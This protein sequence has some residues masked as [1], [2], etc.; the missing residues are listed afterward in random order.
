MRNVLLVTTGQSNMRGN[1]RTDN[2]ASF[3]LHPSVYRGDLDTRYSMVPYLV[4]LGI[5]R[6]VRYTCLHYAIGESSVVHWTGRV[7]ATVTGSASTPLTTMTM[8]GSSIS[9]GTTICVEGD[10][11]FDPFGFLGAIR[12]AIAARPAFT[13]IYG[14]W[15]NGESDSA[16][17][18]ADYQAALESISNHLLGSGCT[19]VYL[20]LSSKPYSFGG[21]SYDTLQSGVNA[22]IAARVAAGKPVYAGANLWQAMG[23][24]PP[25]YAETGTTYYAHLTDRGQEIHARLWDAAL[26]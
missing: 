6:G 7:G 20:G 12:S 8:G 4:D 21:A 16:T 13:E 19:R 2:G 14:L 24:K 15:S 1:G 10:A 9:G 5:Q 26:R 18:A 22:A 3:V 11:D 23:T 17:S 25:L